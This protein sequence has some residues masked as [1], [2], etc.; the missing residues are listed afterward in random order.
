MGVSKDHCEAYLLYRR[1][2]DLPPSFHAITAP[3]GQ[4]RLQ[5][6][7]DENRKALER[8]NALS[9]RMTAADFTEVDRRLRSAEHRSQISKAQERRSPVI[10][11]ADRKPLGKCPNCG[12]L[13]YE[14]D[15]AYICE[16][17]PSDRHS[18]QFAIQKTILQQPI[19]RS[20]AAK[21]LADHRTDLLH[22][23]VSAKNGRVFPAYLVMNETGVSSWKVSLEFPLA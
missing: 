19:D 6:R 10:D 14:N 16:N 12:G 23:F 9:E 3:D 13:M 20:Q 8:L 4:Q 22:Q 1:A 15:T 2:A 7:R 18:C 17:S 21:L 5:V 11:F